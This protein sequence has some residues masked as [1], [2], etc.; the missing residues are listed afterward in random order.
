[1]NKGWVWMN[2]QKANYSG[3]L[4]QYIEETQKFLLELDSVSV[5]MPSEILSYIILGKLAGDPKL[6]QI[7][8]LLNLNK[9]II[10]KPDQILS[11]LQENANHC[12]TKDP[13]SSTLAPAS[14]LVSSTSNEPY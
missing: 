11:C 13:R 5:K 8:E 3:N 2:W 12:Q 6:S 14:A 10:E 1:M 7:V 9:E 4:H